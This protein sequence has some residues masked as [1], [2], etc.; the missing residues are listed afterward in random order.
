MK[1]SSKNFNYFC[2]IQFVVV[3]SGCPDP[4]LMKN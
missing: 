2:Q 3:N 4:K 1:M